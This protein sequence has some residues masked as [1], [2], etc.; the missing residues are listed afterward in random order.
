MQLLKNKYDISAKKWRLTTRGNSWKHTFF[1]THFT[2]FDLNILSSC[3]VVVQ[4]QFDIVPVQTSQE[5]FKV[6]KENKNV[7]WK[8]GD[9]KVKTAVKLQPKQFNKI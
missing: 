7:Y 1:F 4:K 8:K 3:V 9:K 5:R 2:P 6:G